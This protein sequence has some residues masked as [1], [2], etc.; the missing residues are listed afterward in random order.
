MALES[1]NQDG[2][3]EE[4]IFKALHE[5]FRKLDENYTGPDGTTATV[6]LLLDGKVWVANVGDSRTILV[7]DGKAIQ[8]S[9]DAKPTMA[10][11]KKKIEKLGGEVIFNRVNGYLAVARAIGD[12][13]VIGT[14][15][16]CCV[17]PSPIITTYS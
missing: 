13:S 4:G 16:Q 15:G 17:S 5:C 2:L 12:K 7:K 9:E 3:T 1:N 6:A 11:Y 14:T 8:A 10:R